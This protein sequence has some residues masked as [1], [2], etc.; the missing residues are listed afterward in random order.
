ML[1]SLLI[2]KARHRRITTEGALLGSILHHG[3]CDDIAVVSDDAGQFNILAHALCWIH[4]ECLIHKLIPLNEGH[5]QGMAKIRDQVWCFYR[6]LKSIKP[7]LART[8]VKYLSS[9]SMKS[10][11]NRHATKH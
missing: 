9:V 8:N 11:L 4:T 5:R 6:A 3:L 7:S 10:S 2:I 1:D